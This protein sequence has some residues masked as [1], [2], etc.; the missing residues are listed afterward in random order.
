MITN[1][2]KWS[3][4]KVLITFDHFWWFWSFLIK[5][6]RGFLLFAFTDPSLCLLGLFSGSPRIVLEL[7]SESEKRP[8]RIREQSEKDEYRQ[9]EGNEEKE[10]P[11]LHVSTPKSCLIFTFLLPFFGYA[12]GIVRVLK[13]RSRTTPE[14]HPN[15]GGSGVEEKGSMLKSGRQKARSL[16]SLFPSV[17][18]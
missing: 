12:S 16:I 9:R 11:D 8:R 15:K 18:A 3:K 1:D 7:F 17:E 14:Q 13:G 5:L 10:P 2:Q 4:M 6:L